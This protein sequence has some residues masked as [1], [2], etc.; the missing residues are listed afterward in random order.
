MANPATV[1]WEVRKTGSN[2]N[3]GG[4]DPVTG[5]GHV[6]YS[7]QDTFQLQV[8]DAVTD[9]TDQ[10]VSATGGFTSDMIGNCV[11]LT[12]KTANTVITAVTDTNTL[13]MSQTVSAGSGLTATIGGARLTVQAVRTYMLAGNDVHVKVGTYTDWSAEMNVNLSATADNYTNIAGYNTTRLD[14]DS[15]LALTRPTLQ[16]S[17][18]GNYIM[19]NFASGS[20]SS[21]RN[22]IIDGNSGTARCLNF[23]ANVRVHNVKCMGSTG[24]WGSAG[25]ATYGAANCT[26]NYCE[27]T[28]ASNSTCVY[29]GGAH[30]FYYCSFHDSTVRGVQLASGV[31]FFVNC[32]FYR[33]TGATTDGA[34]FTAAAAAGVTFLNCVFADNGRNGLNFASGAGGTTTVYNSVFYGNAA[35]GIDGAAVLDGLWVYNCAFGANGT[36]AYDTSDVV[37]V[38]NELTLTGDPFTDK[39]NGDFT[40]NN[41]AGAGKVLQSAG[42]APS[43][44]GNS[45]RGNPTVGADSKKGG[46]ASPGVPPPAEGGGGR[47]IGG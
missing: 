8:T 41:T 7:Q 34:D 30:H 38:I 28:G 35:Y 6:D 9:G 4:F 40:I 47:V 15:N 3:S 33:N 32:L 5:S 31:S 2:D 13:T 46:G 45:T 16:R 23:T 22:F 26:S 25:I 11:F 20:H 37:H 18:N 43:Y 1:V 19:I 21:I 10:L 36:A 42:W 12:A 44:P 27:F 39:A 14:C 17:A 24:A 29:V